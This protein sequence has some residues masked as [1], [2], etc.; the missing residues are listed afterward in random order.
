MKA[1]KKGTTTWRETA[2]LDADEVEFTGQFLYEADGVTPAMVWDATLQNVRPKNAQD[3][4]D[5]Q[6]AIDAAEPF[7]KDLLD[8]ADTAIVA[9]NT[10]LDIADSATN[11]QVRDQVK[12][13]TQQNQRVIKLL[14]RIVKRSQFGWRVG[15]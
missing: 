9:N 12:R 11:L 10:Y 2:T 5:E 15:L 6:V 3:R 4:A 13:L 8:D 14:A 7:L 1:I